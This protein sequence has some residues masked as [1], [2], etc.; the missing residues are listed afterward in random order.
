MEIERDSKR[1][2]SDLPEA[3][4]V[5]PVGAAFF[6][7]MALIP[8]A[9]FA[10][11]V[12]LLHYMLSGELFT[13]HFDQRFVMRGHIGFVLFTLSTMLVFPYIAIARPGKG[14]GSLYF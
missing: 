12:P 2:R 14:V 10:L 7:A 5:G 4:K 8:C 11:K 9:W 6:M 3:C 13:D 1:K